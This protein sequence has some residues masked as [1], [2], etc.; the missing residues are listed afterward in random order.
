MKDV[1][2][3]LERQARRERQVVYLED[4]LLAGRFWRYARYRL[5]YFAARYL[6]AALL[7]AVK[8]LLLY[9]IF[10]RRTFIILLLGEAFVGFASS[11]WWGALEVMRGR[12]RLL[13]R[14]GRAYL[15]PRELRRWLALSSYPAALALGLSI[16]WLGWSAAAGGRAFGAAHLYGFALL[17][18][19]ALQFV[20]RTYHSGV[21]ALRRVYRPL[22]AVVAVELAAFGGVLSLWPVLGEWSLPLGSLLATTVGA[23]LTFVYARR[24]YRFLGLEP[25]WEWNAA[26]LRPRLRITP[27][28]FF[29]AG[30][31]YAIMKLDAALVLGLF[32]PTAL[33]GPA[34]QLFVLF[35]VMSPTIQA[36]FDWAQL[37][38]FDLKR[39]EARAFGALLAQYRRSLRRLAWMMG[40]VFWALGSL[41]ATVIYL[42]S[43]GEVYWWLAPFFVSRALVAAVQIDAFCA[44]RYGTLLGTASVWLLGFAAAMWIGDARAKLAIV[45]LATFGVYVALRR[46]EARR[47]NRDALEEHVGVAEWLGRLNAVPGPVRVRSLELA[48]A[49]AGRPQGG[50]LT[51]GAARWGERKIARRIAARLRAS[52]A[53]TLVPRHRIVWF[54]TEKSRPMP[55]EWIV[56]LCGGAARAIRETMCPD[57]PTALRRA[58][59]DH[60]LQGALGRFDFDRA[61][62]TSA[63]EL[64]RAFA[65]LFPD[66]AVYAPGRRGQ[67][68]TPLASAYRRTIISDA[69]R[70]AVELRPGRR[71][72]RFEV[73]G[74]C[75]AGQL[76][77]IFVADRYADPRRRRRWR[78]TIRQANVK[79]ALGKVALTPPQPAG[80]P[81]TAV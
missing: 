77:L 68:G 14:R 21:Y 79:A 3:W 8:V 61:R 23:A 13:Y 75:L 31:S 51:A 11:F 62:P 66:G 39:L 35:F 69:A 63:G 48:A 59:I 12:V 42:R 60:A 36:G 33:Y 38:Y 1:D 37:F 73:T 5:R 10:S 45:S 53:V 58:W 47:L 71:R 52:G 32:D 16:V 40:V 4:A 9:S 25:S 54:E 30:L 15:I 26:T 80:A 78:E 27:G 6:A 72:S 55:R 74:L 20:T 70:F 2:A 57:G 34:V 28:E 65:R 24:V 81:V 64:E 7:H 29:G 50:A 22:W 67:N 44:R 41:T 49:K 76:E 46:A 56:A 17:V 18:R 19:L 43:L